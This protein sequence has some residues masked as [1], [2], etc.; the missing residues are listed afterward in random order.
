MGPER[1][2]AEGTRVTKDEFIAAVLRLHPELKLEIDA[3]GTEWIRGVRLKTSDRD[4][5]LDELVGKITPE[6]RHDET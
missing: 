6:N 1:S 5:D 3:D 4:Y 2:R